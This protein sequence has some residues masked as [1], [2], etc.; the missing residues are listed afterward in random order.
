MYVGGPH[1]SQL[2]G[3]LVD[4]L[5]MMLMVVVVLLMMFMQL[6][7][8]S[9]RLMRLLLM[10][11]L[12]M[13]VILLLLRMLL[14]RLLLLLLGANL[15]MLV[16]QLVGRWLADDAAGDTYVTADVNVTAAAEGDVDVVVVDAVADDGGRFVVGK[17]V[18]DEVVVAA[19]WCYLMYV[20]GPSCWL[21][22]L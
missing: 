7:L 4:G 1:C 8:L 19:A 21:L 18:V 10:L 15:C 17:D 22:A 20:V 3:W 5:L 14:L 2:V 11:L 13:V 12:L 9:V 16:V 6:L